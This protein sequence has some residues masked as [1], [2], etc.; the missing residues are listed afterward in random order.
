ML[1]AIDDFGTGY[2]SLNYVRRF[3]VDI[4]KIDKSFIDELAAASGRR[5]RSRARSSQLA[6]HL[7]M[8]TI[9]E[10]V[11]DAVQV[12]RLA[13]ARLRLAQGFHFARP[14]TADEFAALL[15]TR[16]SERL[17]RQRPGGRRAAPRLSRV[18]RGRQLVGDDKVEVGNAR[19][20]SSS[21]SP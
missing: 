6:H 8:Q 2:S 21:P 18:D 17:G 20:R 1:L 11:E 10:G 5:R 3:P 13:G 16:A 19:Q 9:A 7:G 4:L 12:R 14:L 15:G